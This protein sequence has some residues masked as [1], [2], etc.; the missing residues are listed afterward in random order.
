MR[1]SY[2]RIRKLNNSY[3][4][5]VRVGIYLMIGLFNK[6]ITSFRI[7][8]REYNIARREFNDIWISHHGSV[9]ACRYCKNQV[10][11][12]N[13]VFNDNQWTHRSILRIQNMKMVDGKPEFKGAIDVLVKVVRNEGLFALWKGFFPYYARLGPHTVLTFVFLEQMTAAYKTRYA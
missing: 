6:S 9:D 3:S 10:N 2:R 4:I 12:I 11:L 13:N 8:P 1:L 7:F 5:L